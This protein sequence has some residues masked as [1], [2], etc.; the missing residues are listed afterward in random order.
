MKIFLTHKE[1]RI[2]STQDYKDKSYD[3][4]K[5]NFIQMNFNKLNANVDDYIFNSI[6]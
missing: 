2:L 3:F 4:R 6:K 5:Q 1:T